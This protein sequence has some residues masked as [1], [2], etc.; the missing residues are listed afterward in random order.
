MPLKKYSP[1]GIEQIH[2]TNEL[3]PN[4]INLDDYGILITSHYVYLGKIYS[5]YQ[6]NSGIQI[7]VKDNI[8]NDILNRDCI[9]LKNKI[10][11]ITYS[12]IYKK[13]SII[14]SRILG[15]NKLTFDL[16]GIL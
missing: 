16:K 6:Y 9:V 8:E 11:I 1:L 3:Y 13:Y 14:F 10:K 7:L 2:V 15:N 5:L 12:D 4:S